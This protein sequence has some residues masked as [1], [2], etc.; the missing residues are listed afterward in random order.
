MDELV[1]AHLETAVEPVVHRRC[2][3]RHDPE[4]QEC[5]GDREHAQR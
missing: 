2:C 5:G 3:Q 1:R 4:P